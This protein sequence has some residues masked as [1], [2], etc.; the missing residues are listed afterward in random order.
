MSVE[1]CMGH[2]DG[3]RSTLQQNFNQYDPNYADVGSYGH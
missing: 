2:L 1:N 3:H